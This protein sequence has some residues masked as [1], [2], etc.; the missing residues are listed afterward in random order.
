[1]TVKM[2]YNVGVDWLHSCNHG[3]IVK[4]STKTKKINVLPYEEKKPTFQ[5]NF[6]YISVEKLLWVENLTW[7]ITFYFLLIEVN[8]KS[9]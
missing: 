6:N 2:L 4:T 8:L 1:M 5:L 7:K 3:K 9:T